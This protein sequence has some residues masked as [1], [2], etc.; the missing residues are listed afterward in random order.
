MLKLLILQVPKGLESEVDPGVELEEHGGQGS[1]TGKK[2]RARGSCPPRP[3]A[4]ES[5]R[6]RQGWVA[7]R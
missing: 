6:H 1:E 3:E 2:I 7:A 4:A 5:A